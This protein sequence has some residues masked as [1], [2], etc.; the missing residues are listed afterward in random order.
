M[1]N[2]HSSAGPYRHPAIV[3]MGSVAELTKQNIL[4]D[5]CDGTPCTGNYRYY[6]AGETKDSKADHQH[7]PK[8]PL[9]K[10]K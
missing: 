3:H 10:A 8:F 2:S 9:T 4:G 7:D 1:S 5:I 6:K